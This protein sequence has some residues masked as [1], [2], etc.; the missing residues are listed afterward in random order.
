MAS[1]V[2][3]KKIAYALKLEDPHSR[4]VSFNGFSECHLIKIKKSVGV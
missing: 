1:I 3:V 2:E 4:V